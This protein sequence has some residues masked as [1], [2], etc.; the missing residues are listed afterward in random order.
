MSDNFD[1][2]I[3]RRVT[4]SAKWRA[5]PADVLPLWVADMDFM[6]PGPVRRALRAAVDHGVFGY[7]RGLHG[8][9]TDLPEFVQTI[10]ERLRD[11]Y[12]WH[13]ELQDVIFLPGVVIGLNVVCNMFR[14]QGG[15]I[16]VQPPVY[17]PILDAPQT[18]GL[19]RHEALLARQ[20]DG[21]YA[22]DWDQLAAALQSDTRAFILCNPHNPV[23]RAFRCDELERMAELCLARDVLI[24]SDE[25][26][27][28]LIYKNLR[29]GMQPP[30]GSPRHIP[31]AS[32]DPEIAQHSITFFAP[33]KTFNLPGL[34]ASVVIIQNA[35]LRQRF[36]AARQ[37][38]VPWV[39]VMGLTAMQAAYRDG[40]AWLAELLPYLEANRDFVHDFVRTELPG[41]SMAKPE[42]TYLAWIDCRG[43]NLENPYEFFLNQARVALSNGAVF[44][45]GGQGFVRLN[46]GCPRSTLEEA[47]QRMKQALLA[48]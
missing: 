15:S 21:T 24:C 20:R 28:D 16:A 5:Y 33:S 32:F 46:F 8:D 43:A 1:Q 29:E 26:H 17:T 30:G 23:G 10:V 19:T 41:L 48:R 47:L 4:E 13:V 40:Q 34:Q 18:A 2:V 9:A 7:P 38:L 35:E 12:A 27:G 36:Q 44:G 39:N 42:G 3:N 37:V 22:V 6:S 14:A 11:Q 25:I 45:T 31:I